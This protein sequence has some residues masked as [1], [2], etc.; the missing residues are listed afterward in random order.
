MYFQWSDPLPG[1][2][3]CEDCAFVLPCPCP[4]I[5]NEPIAESMEPSQNNQAASPKRR[6][7]AWMV[8]LPTTH[9]KVVIK[10]DQID[11]NGS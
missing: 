6:K 1:D 10:S 11:N 9:K 3:L 8:S 7:S 4:T 2:R 5:L